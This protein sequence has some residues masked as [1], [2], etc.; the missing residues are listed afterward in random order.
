[1]FRKT[2]RVREW[3]S[4]QL[5]LHF[6]LSL[7]IADIWRIERRSLYVTLVAKFLVLN[8]PWFRK[9]MAEETKNWQNFWFSTTRGFAN[10]WQKRRKNWHIWLYMIALRNKTLARKF[11]LSFD[12]ANGRLFQERLPTMERDI[13]LLLSIGDRHKYLCDS[14]SYWRDFLKN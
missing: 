3:A 12:N 1:M 8:K 4:F 9:Y 7:K 2:G 13:T 6:P 14:L 11:L 10:I 5:K